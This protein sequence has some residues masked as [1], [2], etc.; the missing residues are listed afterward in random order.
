M[1]TRITSSV[2]CPSLDQLPA[3][4]FSLWGGA[5]FKPSSTPVAGFPI[6]KIAHSIHWNSKGWG[7]LLILWKGKCT[8]KHGCVLWWQGDLWVEFLQGSCPTLR[9]QFSTPRSSR[10]E[11]GCLGPDFRSASTGEKNSA[12][13]FVA[14]SKSS[15]HSPSLLLMETGDSNNSPCSPWTAAGSITWDEM[16]GNPAW[17]K[18]VSGV[19]HGYQALSSGRLAP[20]SFLAQDSAGHSQDPPPAW[21]SLGTFETTLLTM[22]WLKIGKKQAVW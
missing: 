4:H 10:L 3:V 2:L 18:R 22:G 15:Y 7:F 16:W 1:A 21:L 11:G 5:L 6:W 8:D 17:T 13:P 20:G 19:L 12:P 9:Q 14:F